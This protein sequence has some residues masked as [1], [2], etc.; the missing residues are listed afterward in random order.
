M[1]DITADQVNEAVNNTV[2]M[3]KGFLS[4]AWDA[5]KENPEIAL[6]AVGAVAGFAFGNG[7]IGGA[8]GAGLG[9]L[10]SQFLFAANP[11]AAQTVPAQA[12]VIQRSD[13]GF[14]GPR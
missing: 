8:I 14:A 1:I 10:A 7:A 9:Y 2:E 3:G 6:T 11:A 13:P 12:P 4:K 5:V